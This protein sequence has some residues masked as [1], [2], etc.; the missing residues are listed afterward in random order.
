[1]QYGYCTDITNILK[2]NY[3]MLDRIVK[4]G[5]DYVEFSLTTVAAI[6]EVDF[7]RVSE[8]KKRYSLPLLCCNGMY[9][10]DVRLTGPAV[11]EGKVKGYTELALCRASVLGAKKCV[12]GSNGARNLPEGFSEEEGYPQ[13]ISLIK[14]I[15]A[16]IAEKYDMC[17]VIEPLRRPATNFINTVEEG[18]MVVNGVQHP[19]IKVLADTIHMLASKEDPSY[20]SLIVDSL[21]HVHVSDYDRVLPEDGYSSDLINVLNALNEAGYDDTIS[22]ETKAG[23]RNS[24]QFLALNLLKQKLGKF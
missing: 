21:K 17:I 8:W 5:Y 16:P 23:M 11:D 7:T 18:M 6:S 20:L 24:S 9:P 19:N 10:S 13:F 3:E 15:I 2:G 1:M 14:R 22:F 4:A 12:L